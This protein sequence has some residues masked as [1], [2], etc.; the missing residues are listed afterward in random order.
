[1][2]IHNSRVLATLCVLG[3]LSSFGCESDDNGRRE[4]RADRIGPSA[5]SFSG[6]GEPTSNS[7]DFYAHGVTLRPAIVT[8]QLVP[9]ALC[10]TRPPFLAPIQLVAVADGD[11]DLFLNQVDVRFVDRKGVFGGAMSLGR[12][13]LVDLFGSTRI[14][15]RG[16]R[17]FPIT[18]PFGCTGLSEGTLTVGVFTGDARGRERRHSL[19]VDVR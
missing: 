12:S 19:S 11:L 5:I 4:D 18:L 9:G 7:V 10:P 17:L 3:T 13:Q 2:S 16:R 8:P 15:G 14:P 1:M 6:I